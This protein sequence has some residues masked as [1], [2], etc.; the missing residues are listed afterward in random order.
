MDNIISM[1]EELARRISVWSQAGSEERST[2]YKEEEPTSIE[3]SLS[4]FKKSLV[5]LVL[6]YKRWVIISM[7]EELARR[8]YV[9]T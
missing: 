2:S 4:T 5:R 3:F 9:W 7:K 8:I 6:P 1:K